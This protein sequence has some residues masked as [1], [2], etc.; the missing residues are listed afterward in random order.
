M[1]DKRAIERFADGA[2]GKEL[3]ERLTGYFSASLAGLEHVPRQG[4]ALLVANHGM[5]GLDGAVLGALLQREV[6]RL[7]FWLAERNLWR[8]PGFG[9]LA[10]FI[11]AVPGE[12]ET[13]VSLLRKGELVVVYPGGIDDSFKLWTARQK[14]QWGRRS[15]FARVAMGASVPI[16]P[17]AAHGVDD[18]YTTLIREPWLGR[19]LLGS[20]KYDLPISF[21]RWGTWLPR[22]VKV[23]IQALAPVDTSGDPASETDVERVRSAVFEAIQTSLDKT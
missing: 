18:M 5:N 14:L 23:T 19:A 8:I 17:V 20:A 13:A 9:R 16:V 21:G 7:P 4:G 1:T 10:S 22:R 15:G 11:D 6:G 3:I 2:A 12:R